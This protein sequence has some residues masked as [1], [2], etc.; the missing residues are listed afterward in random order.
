[1]GQRK[2]MWNKLGRAL[3]LIPLGALAAITIAMI[4]PIQSAQSTKM[5]RAIDPP[6]VSA[7][8]VFVMNATTGEVLYEKNPDEVFRTLSLTKLVT[9]YLLVDRM[10]DRL[11][12]TMEISAPHLTGGSSANLKRRDVWTLQDLLY[13]MVLVSGNDASLAIADAVGRDLLAADGKSGDTAKATRRFVIEMGIAARELGARNASFADPYGL[14]AKNAA[15]ARDMGLIAARVFTDPRLLPAWA[16]TKRTLNIQGKRPRAVVL[17]TSLKI[18]GDE[19]VIGAKT[20]SYISKGIFN[21]VAAWNAPNGQTIVGVV[22]GSKSDAARYGGMR[23]LIE[24]A[25]RDFPQLQREA[26]AAD[27]PPTSECN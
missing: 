19:S 20:G 8:S 16:C 6:N 22:L 7:R 25:P 18:L 2:I 24:A 11:S 13:G 4:E 3:G 27:P 10:G 14:S 5:N 9:A 21:L 17:K 26:V 23:A 1:M 12:E 15:T